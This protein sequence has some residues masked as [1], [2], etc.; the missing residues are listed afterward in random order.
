MLETERLLM[1]KFTPDDLDKLIELRSDAEV[2]KYLGGRRLQNPEAISKRLQFYIGCYE[3]YGFGFMAMIWT[4][5][6][7]MIG[8]SGLQPLGDT[9]EIEI[10]YGMKKEFWGWGIGYECARAWL[11]F[12]F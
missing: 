9:N 1:R 6:G 3:K 10:G 2:I 11:K 8:W 7:E 4:K 12:G 5:T